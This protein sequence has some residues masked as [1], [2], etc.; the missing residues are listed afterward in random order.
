MKR[1]ILAVV[2]VAGSQCAAGVESFLIGTQL[3]DQCLA[4]VN[5]TN[6][7]KGNVCAAYIAGIH[8]IQRGFVDLAIVGSPIWCEPDEGRIGQVVRV[9]LK[10]LEASP[11]TLHMPASGRVLMAFMQAFPCE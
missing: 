3:L 10:F 9:V 1:I 8:D 5:D 6:V 2:L 11:E 4:Y 7:A